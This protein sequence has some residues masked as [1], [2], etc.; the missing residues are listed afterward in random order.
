MF[1][2]V[3]GLYAIVVYRVHTFCTFYTALYTLYIGHDT[4]R[5]SS[6]LARSYHKD[7]IMRIKSFLNIAL[8]AMP[9]MYDLYRDGIYRIYIPRLYTLYITE[10]R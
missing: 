1:I 7:I 6:T 3:C 8:V 10:S 9:S 4:T 5:A 2:V